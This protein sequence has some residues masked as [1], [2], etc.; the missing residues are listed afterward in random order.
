MSGT[1]ASSRCIEVLWRFDRD[2]AHPFDKGSL[3]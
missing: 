2:A 3:T 1:A